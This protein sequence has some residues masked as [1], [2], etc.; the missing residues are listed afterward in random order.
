VLGRAGNSVKPILNSKDGMLK[1]GPVAFVQENVQ[2]NE[3]SVQ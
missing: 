3:R 2:R 1:H